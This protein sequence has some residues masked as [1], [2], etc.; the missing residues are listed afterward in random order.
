MKIS[1][2]LQGGCILIAA[3]VAVCAGSGWFGFSRL[4]S[5]L[6]S[7][8]GPVMATADGAAKTTRSVF[9]QMLAVEKILGNDA[10]NAEGLI[11]KAEQEADKAFEKLSKSGLL[12]AE[13][14]DVIK[15][16]QGHF[17]DIKNQIIEEHKAFVAINAQLNQSFLEF[18]E[19]IGLAKGETAIALRNA[20]MKAGKKRSSDLS[21]LGQQWAVA[22][23]SKETQIYL[24]EAKYQ[25]ET[26]V[27][28][29]DKLARDEL[30]TTLL[31]L[32]ESA[33]D[34]AA[35]EFFTLQI[36]SS[37]RY[38]G[39]LFSDAFTEA[40]AKLEGHL[41]MAVQENV[42]LAES[43]RAYHEVS[44][45]LIGLVN[46]TEVTVTEKVDEQIEAIAS[47][48]RFAMIIIFLTAFFGLAV[49]AFIIFA[50]VNVMV[51]W[52]QQTQKVMS[53]LSAGRLNLQFDKEHV[54]AGGDDLAEIN[55]AIAN[56]VEQFSR[57]VKEMVENTKVVSDISRQIS[58]SADSISSGANDQA[59]SVEETSAS[60]E[61]ISATV[62]QNSK[63][64]TSTKNL[65]MKTAASASE[66]GVAVLEMVGAMRKIAQKVSIID[67]IAYQTNLLALN[68]SIEASR[69]GDDGRGFA[70]VAAEVR[71]LAERS[72]IAASE[73]IEMADETVSVSEAAGAQL[74]EILPNIDKTS[75]LVQEIA[76]A[77]DEQSSG[78]HEI[79][80]AISQLDKVAQ[81]NASSALQLTKMSDE[82]DASILKLDEVIRFFEVSE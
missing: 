10:K 69:A 81:H 35:S 67:D 58:Q 29:H 23:L 63:N 62:M 22:D 51:K 37:G 16:K 73:V 41:R 78:L 65:A 15:K 42:Q 66:S 55:D 45:G 2:K 54:L 82:M 31:N 28:S 18:N 52:L 64:A 50:V 72:K 5:S 8:T 49:S 3:M 70:V 12:G 21:S 17:N 36:V 43:R 68:A 76:A 44:L 33:A 57:V 26:F 53:E 4:S 61:Q 30:D 79:T 7:I 59:S 75:E 47:S 1:T 71:K 27:S 38:E 40:F 46:Q 32:E 11:K 80:F 14:L 60:I 77:S 34:A 56:V 25:F 19:L 48:R 13:Q 24:L 74:T 6:D 39:K 20:L 9:E